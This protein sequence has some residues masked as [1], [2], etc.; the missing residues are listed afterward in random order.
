[1]RGMTLALSLVVVCSAARADTPWE[2][3]AFDDSEESVRLAV[4]DSQR[5][6]TQ[7]TDKVPSVVRVAE[8]TNAKPPATVLQLNEEMSSRLG[9]QGYRLE[10]SGKSVFIT[11]AAPAGLVNGLYGLLRELGYRFNLGSE[12]VPKTLPDALPHSPIERKPVLTTRG[13]LPWYNFFNSP[14]AWDLVDHRAF[15]DQLIRMGANFVGF[16]TYDAEPFAGYFEEG[17][18]KY[19]QRLLN[20]ASPTWGTHPLNTQDFGFD[21]GL[22]YAQDY[23]GAETTRLELPEPEVIQR[24]QDIMRAALDYA[25]RRGLTTCLGFEMN[26][27]PTVPAMRD[28]FLKRLHHLMDQYPMLDVIWL[29]QSETQGVQGFTTQYSQHILPFALQVGSPLEMYGLARRQTFARVVCEVV[30]EKPFYQDNEQG[31]MARATE[32]ARLEQFACLALRAM[33]QRANPPRLAISGWGGDQRLLSADYYDGLD[34]LLPN[35]V[36][37]TSLDHIQPRERVDAVYRLL[38]ETREHWPIPWLENDGDQWHPQPYVRVYEKMMRDLIHGGSQGVLGIHWRTRCIEENFSYLVEA[39]WD[40]NVSAD[41]FFVD[42]AEH[43]FDPDIADEMAEILA[44]LDRLGYLWTGGTGQ[45]ECAPFS[46]GVPDSDTLERFSALRSRVQALSSNA[47]SR[48]PPLEW[49]LARMDWVWHYAQAK[50][51]V[52]EATALRDRAQ[53]TNGDERKQLAGQGLALLDKGDLVEAMHAYARRLTTRGEYGVLAIINTKAYV[54]WRALREEL[55]ALAGKV[56]ERR[57]PA[58]KPEPNILLPRF[59]GTVPAKGEFVVEPI[60]LGGGKA[61]AHYRALGEDNWTTQILAPVQGWVQRAIVP[62]KALCAPGFEVGF[63]FH[64][65]PKSA[66]AFGP[67][68]VTVQEL[69]EPQ[70]IP[71]GRQVASVAPAG[72]PLEVRAGNDLLVELSWDDLPQA[73]YFRVYR[74]GEPVVETAVP[75]FPDCPKTTKSVYKVEAVRGE[76]VISVSDPI[77]VDVTAFDIAPPK[78]VGALRLRRNRMH[79]LLHWETPWSPMIAQFRIERRAPGGSWTLVHEVPARADQV[80]VWRDAAPPGHWEYQVT[81]VGPTGLTGA[82]ARAEIE[83]APLDGVPAPSLEWPLNVLP[84]GAVQHGDVKFNGTGAVFSGGHIEV[85]HREEMNLGEG[86]TL[87]FEFKADRVTPMPVL[88]SHGTWTDDGWFAQILGGRLI[89]RMP[90]G[91]AE[92]PIIEPGRWYHVDFVFDGL[93]A[94]LAVDGH[95]QPQSGAL[96]QP[97]PAMR[98]LLIGGYES[99]ADEHRFVGETRN[100]R[101]YNDV[102]LE[103]A[104]SGF[105]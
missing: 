64:E 66:M 61:Y 104:S 75:F 85:P 103:P 89:V 65:D 105:P 35:D 81:P 2:R 39:S 84:A 91:D 43:V 24:E 57:E 45:N 5:Y 59:L 13:V 20:T 80:G 96:I 55:A 53:R 56:P 23:F 95:W 4:V 90:K 41:K 30:G 17:T 70:S 79:V 16:H 74:N 48:C 1:M 97:K 31:R 44:S 94:H 10:Q 32:G 100:I 71:L 15:L 52:H 50:R 77:T 18:V 82:A 40:S 38:P 101:I 98:P 19:G 93:F 9:A 83:F 11:A 76:S 51:G 42:K 60:I 67:V 21:T 49:L 25:K 46:W 54:A 86:M 7:V 69:P 12:T 6:I 92:G 99:G 62:G 87:H 68:C 63:S 88:L 73:D 78:A 58:W 72:F 47:K 36:I 29:W 102:V 27:D 37:F 26:G 3:F 34:K 8:W 22:L 33:A 28:A 14:T